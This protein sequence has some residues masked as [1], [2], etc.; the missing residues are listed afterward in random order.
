MFIFSKLVYF[1]EKKKKKKKEE[2]KKTVVN[3]NAILSSQ[4]LKIDIL[5]LIFDVRHFY[6]MYMKS[7]NLLISFRQLGSVFL[8]EEGS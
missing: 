3:L 4:N 5:V 8:F 7:E 6:S 2:E 1:W